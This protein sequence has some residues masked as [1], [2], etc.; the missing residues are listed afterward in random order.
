MGYIYMQ[1]HSYMRIYNCWYNVPILWYDTS[2]DYHASIRVK[3]YLWDLIDTYYYLVKF[4]SANASK[5]LVNGYIYMQYLSYLSIYK[6]WYNVPILWYD[7]SRDYH[8][9]IRIKVYL[10]DFIDT[11]YYLVKFAS[12][13]A[14]KW[15]T[16]GYA[17]M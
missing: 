7:T 11:Y 6:Y 1:Y 17:Y 9:S 14:S 8:A 12:T 10:W 5:W 2:R 13:N 15:L 4:A 3:V 16:N